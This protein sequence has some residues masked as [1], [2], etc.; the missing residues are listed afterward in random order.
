[1]ID[2][3]PA[4]CLDVQLESD[5]TAALVWRGDAARLPPG[6]RR[7]G[8]AVFPS[9]AASLDALQARDMPPPRRP[10][11]GDRIRQRFGFKPAR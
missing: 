7:L 8:I 9:V 4:Y 10:G 3:Q 6:T 2:D 1:M 5:A 11:F